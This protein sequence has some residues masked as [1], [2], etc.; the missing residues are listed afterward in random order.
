[1]SES[2]NI[3]MEMR[4]RIDHVM[5]RDLY[6]YVS[7]MTDA[8]DQALKN[9]N[10]LLTK[11]K[12]EIIE[13]QARENALMVATLSILTGG[14]A[15]AFADGLVKRLP[16]VEKAASGGAQAIAKVVEKAEEDPVLYK[17]FKD[18]TKDLVKKGV[19]KAQEF[20][21]DHF[22][23]EPPSDGFQPVGMTVESYR[24]KLQ[25]GL[26]VRGEIL[27]QFADL[28]LNTADSWTPELAR[29]LREGL[30]NNDFFKRRAPLH[31]DVLVKKAE[32]A[33]WSAWALVRDEDYWTTQVAM[34][35]YG[36]R[37]SEVWHWEPLLRRLAELDVPADVITINPTMYLPGGLKHV[38]GLD[39]IGFM[40]WV[41]KSAMVHTLFDGIP[42]DGGA[43]QRAAAKMLQ[44]YGIAISL[45]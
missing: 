36:P 37:M 7:T 3:F 24:A 17:I 29:M 2:W 40:K 12:A 45:A 30:Y 39:M 11:V 16:A 27:W 23:A 20:G 28:L 15:G 19:E 34:Q 41:R 32:L 38:Q 5:L 21:L 25:E 1:M 26:S 9:V 42:V 43:Y 31:R 6:N 22:K 10:D 44:A 18:T 4:E 8:Y 13:S 33:L 14:V 35:N